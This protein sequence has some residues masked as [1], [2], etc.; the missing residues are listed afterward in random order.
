MAKQRYKRVDSGRLVQEIL[1]TGINPSDPPKMRA[2]KTKLSTKARQRLNDKSSWKNLMRVLAI[3]FSRAD[4]VLTLTFA[5]GFLPAGRQEARLRLKK[6]LELLREEWRRRGLELKYVYSL[7]GFYPGGRPHVHIVINGSHVA[8]QKI[9][10]L[11]AYGSNLKF[12]RLNEYGYEDLARYL[13]KEAREYGRAKVGERSWV[14]SRT[15][16]RPIIEPTQWVAE[17]FGLSPPPDAINIKREVVEN[18]WGR[19]IYLEYLLPRRRQKKR[20]GP[21]LKIKHRP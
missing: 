1:Y 7:E 14:C 21:K 13:S 2:E 9:R 12:E 18:E 4:L 17:S 3:N 5:D 15:I 16:K 11:W 20:D 8:Y 19:Y 10:E 6:F